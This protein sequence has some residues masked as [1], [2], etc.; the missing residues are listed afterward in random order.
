MNSAVAANKKKCPSVRKI[1][2]DT[3]LPQENFSATME[4]YIALFEKNKLEYVIF[5]HLGDFH[6]HCNLLPKNNDELRRALL[7]Y[8]DIMDLTIKNNGTISAEHGIGKIKTQHLCGMY[9]NEVMAEM[10]RIKSDFDPKWLLNRGNLF[11]RLPDG[12]L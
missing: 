10:R 11:E 8:D 9:G 2:T 1:S 6:L 3:A 4:N 7:V 12:I 5:G